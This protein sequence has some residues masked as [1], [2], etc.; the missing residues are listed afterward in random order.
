MEIWIAR[1]CDG[2]VAQFFGGEPVL[3]GEEYTP[4]GPRE[5][6]R[7]RLRSGFRI[8]PDESFPEVKPGECRKAKITLEAP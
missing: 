8:L 2:T 5:T 4:A 1:D 7:Q 3:I 6:L